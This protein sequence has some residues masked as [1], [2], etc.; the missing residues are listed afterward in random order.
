MSRP[1]D[2]IEIDLAGVT[3]PFQTPKVAIIISALMELK[4]QPEVQQEIIMVDAQ[5]RFMKQGLGTRGWE[6]VQRRLDDEDDEL[7][8]PHIVEAFKAVQARSG[9]RPTTSSGES[10]APSPRVT[11]SGAEQSTGVSTSG[12]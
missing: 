2:S 4:G 3:Y 6:D 12:G 5:A 9:A 11:F 10:M 8:W 1:H 7:D